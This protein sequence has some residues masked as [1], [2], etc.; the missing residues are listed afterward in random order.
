MRNFKAT[1]SLV[2][3]AALFGGVAQAEC[4]SFNSALPTVVVTP[5]D[6]AGSPDANGLAFPNAF[7][8]LSYLD[9]GTSA[10]SVQGVF[11]QF[12]VG[13]ATPQSGASAIYNVNG[14]GPVAAIPTTAVGITG[15]ASKVDT[16]VDS[17]LSF[18]NVSAGPTTGAASERTLTLFVV[19]PSSSTACSVDGEIA[20]GS[21]NIITQ[22]TG[23]D[24][25]TAP[26]CG[27]TTFYDEAGTDFTNW[28][29]LGATGFTLSATANELTMGISS[30]APS[31]FAS[32]FRT[33]TTAFQADTVYRLRMN[34]QSTATAGNNEWFRTRMGN[35]LFQMDSGSLEQGFTQQGQAFPTT[36]KNVTQ[37][38][39]AK[40][41]GTGESAPLAAADP[42]GIALDKIET[43]TVAATY[44]T[45]VNSLVIDSTDYACFTS[46]AST[47]LGNFGASSVT[48]NDGYAPSGTA[49]A[50][51]TAFGAGTLV[52]GGS[53]VTSNW[54]TL[55]LP[56]GAINGNGSAFITY[57]TNTALSA[58]TGFSSLFGG[59][60]DFTANATSVY[61]AD[62]WLSAGAVP[63]A[64]TQRLPV[65]RLRFIAA[66]GA[67]A[68][69][70]NGVVLMQLQPSRSFG[71]DGENQSGITAA[72]S[73]RHYRAIFKPNYNGSFGFG[74]GFALDFLFNRGGGE[75]IKPNG[76]ITIE[77]LTITQY[78]EPA[79]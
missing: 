59:P 32:Y 66:E 34:M 61:V 70:E 72:N 30:T 6:L 35:P 46:G 47:V 77:R 38:L 57:N 39:W 60:L 76:T 63:N 78:A 25:L 65:L 13:G 19:A 48:N 5:N 49:S 23:P 21:F 16:A 7:D 4:P 31:G 22:T 33:F 67:N 51:T 54:T 79:F 26:A 9:L 56:A 52:D 28:L 24:E 17:T 42:V 71:A 55:A 40:N 44:N 53:T 64:T 10:T 68:Q 12:A 69:R 27:W 74:T 29:A 50:F 11:A 14:F 75:E 1:L 18:S 2:A 43:G 37:Y 3:V 62:V 8:L 45:V 41:T 73:A 58:Q 36:A 15:A 20:L